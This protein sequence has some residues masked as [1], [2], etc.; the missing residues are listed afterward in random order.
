M[1]AVHSWLLCTFLLLAGLPLDAAATPLDPRIEAAVQTY[2]QQ[3]PEQALPQFEAL[4]REFT[5]GSRTRPTR[6]QRAALHY[7]GE[8]RWRLGQLDA[9]R[10]YLDRAV[11]LAR[12]ARD[13]ADEA[14][15]LNVLGL[16][17][18]DEGRYEEATASFRRTGEIARAAGDRRLE[19][20]ALNNLSLVLDEQGDYETSLRQYQRVLELYRDADFPR[21][22]GDTL[23]NIGGVHLLLGRFRA[24]RGYYEQALA[25]SEQ[26]QS[27]VSMSQDHGN[28]GLSLLGLGDVEAALRHFER[29]I[30]LA[31]Q[32]GLRQDQAYWLRAR[33]DAQV[34]RGRY[35]H[36]LQDY[37]SALATYESIG[38]QAELLET[39]HASGE[40][41]LTL[42]DAAT[43]ER[44]FRRALALARAIGLDRGIA[45]NLLALGDLELRR[46]R[47]DAALEA[48]GQAR[49]RAESAGAD[50]T[51]ARSLL[52]QAGVH[53]AQRQLDV[54]A[55]ETDRALLLARRVEAPALEAEARYA[56][57]ESSRLQGRDREALDDYAAAVAQARR[58]GDPDLLWQVLFGR[59][60]SQEKTGDI[61]GA[62]ASLEEAVELI[63]SVRGRLREARFRSGYVEDKFEVYLELMRLQLQLGRTADAFTTA[64]R[65]RA[66]SFVD[67]LEGRATAPLSGDERRQE[68][69]LRERVRR[70]Q[71]SL[72]ETDDAGAPAYSERAVHHFSAE[73]ARAEAEY[74]AF[75]DDRRGA[76]GGMAAL[77]DVAA[78]QRQ[79]RP[80]QALVEYIVARDRLAAFVL[81]SERLE[82]SV[83]DVT[84]AQLLARVALLR[85][86]LRQPGTGSW[87]K[88]SAR[89]YAELLEPLERAGWLDGIEHLYIVPHGAL[90]TLPFALLQRRAAMP[91]T[92]LID[93]Y[94]VAY[95]PAAA[96][97]LRDVSP[98]DGRTLLA[99][100][101]ARTRL[102]H[103]AAEAQAVDTL[104]RPASTALIGRAA[105]EGRFKQ[106]AGEFGV[107]H[108]ATHGRFNVASPLLSGLEL[109]PDHEEDGMLRVHE[110]LDLRLRANLVTL[111]ACE[112]ALA[113]G[114]FADLP[115]GD[116][117]V[118]LNRAFLAAGSVAVLATLWPVDDR[119]SVTLMTQ[120]YGRLRDPVARHSAAS[121]LAQAQR[122]MRRTPALAHPYYWAAYVVVGPMTREGGTA[123]RSPGR[124]T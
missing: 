84:D 12:A 90:T 59:A 74:Q 22:V 28:L 72:V 39:L 79:L 109:E 65:L 17:A 81:T 83:L 96:A 87:Q 4:A 7:L 67:Q 69:E 6:N 64:E 104:Y 102:R 5:R 14:R 49:A 48:Y 98:R 107:L 103:A 54:A 60:R 56:R 85:D 110:I 10:Q 41:H 55:R 100:A 119:A 21:G 88:P 34:R 66:R 9:A 122:E 75:L 52:R 63:E 112:T 89:L 3:G 93:R 68:A 38:A 114:Y 18:W 20:S 116:G 37:R 15:S 32:A 23:G 105:T 24:A 50:H 78:I 123:P 30:D 82:A 108:L 70:L 58:V 33:G 31:R 121:A 118:G 27:T 45:A 73:L 97:L 106:L 19:G 94:T 62:L 99:V 11:G 92:L 71:Q 29:A 111:S 120:F 117:F 80:G 2:R 76:M 26:L 16:V 53:R 51:L 43:A 42:G 115:V 47:P 101:P 1:R 113:S 61:D 124:R 44:E 77:P 25:I 36:A 8:C 91:T 57:G 86:L 95:L 35:D 40:L 13:A 46:G